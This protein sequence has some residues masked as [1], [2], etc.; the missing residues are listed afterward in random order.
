MPH[1]SASL[2]DLQ[3]SLQILPGIGEK[4]AFRLAYFIVNQPAEKSLRLAKSITDAIEKCRPCSECY[5]LSDTSPCIICADP[6]RDETTLCIV[7]NSKD[8]ALIESTKEYHGRYFVLGKLLSP[9]D[10]IGPNEIRIPEL[11]AF[12]TKN[13]FS[14]IIIAISPSTEGETTIHLIADRI[15][16]KSIVISRLSTGIPYG[17]EME[18]TG[19]TTLQ[20]ALKR[21]FPV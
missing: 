12:I 9:L 15:A 3:K 2:L 19:S 18:Y 11:L 21:R 7:E 16:D 6:Q 20:N 4:T 17:G 8:I 1:I 14:E 13:S 10:G 5:L